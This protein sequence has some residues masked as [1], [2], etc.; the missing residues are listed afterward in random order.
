M[1]N[2]HHVDSCLIRGRIQA[3]LVSEQSTVFNL[4]FYT[5]EFV[6]WPKYH[7]CGLVETDKGMDFSHPLSSMEESCMRLLTMI[8]TSRN[9]KRVRD[10]TDPVIMSLY[11]CRCITL[12]SCF[13]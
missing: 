4:H 10:F 8:V 9:I 7:L 12:F 1:V 11:I 13:P 5:K 3:N 2:E 6:S